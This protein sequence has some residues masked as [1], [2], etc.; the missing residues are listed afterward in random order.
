VKEI[1]Q[2]F[3]ATIIRYPDTIPDVLDIASPDMLITEPLRLA[4]S[5][6]VDMFRADKP[7]DLVTLLKAGGG[8]AVYL[9]RLME[10]TCPLK[11]RLKYYAE[12][13]RKAYQCRQIKAELTRII[14]KVDDEHPDDTIAEVAALVAEH[15]HQSKSSGDILD[16]VARVNAQ[17][18]D[19]RRNGAGLPSGFSFL[20]D[21]THTMHSPGHVWAIG[22]FTSVGKSA[23]SIEMITRMHE[24][25]AGARSCLISTE[26]TESQVVARMIS[27]GSELPTWAILSGKLWDHE[28]E[29]ADQVE[30]WIKSQRLKIFD[31][32]YE[33]T[34]I[35][36]IIRREHLKGGVDMVVVDYMQN[37]TVPGCKSEYEQ[38][39]TTAKAFQRIAKQCKTNIVVLSQ[40]SNDFARNIN[41]GNSLEF[42]GGGTLA[43]VCDLGILL[44][45][46]KNEKTMIMADVRKN[47]H[48]P[49]AK[50]VLQF[51]GKYTRLEEVSDD[52]RNE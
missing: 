47:R 35:E 49:H 6:M 20:D 13:I 32:A 31:D 52:A 41:D 30:E 51:C 48:G 19:T 10:C 24:K 2:S 33:L 3:V 27:R 12:E 16:V 50:Q 45:R 42:K 40:L 8:T 34:N 43:A 4:Y 15:T 9:A 38:H 37:I 17:I 36:G 29:R 25:I 28:K 11:A 39:D 7:V 21:R 46:S 5:T 44:I 23:L 14:T 26:M 1:E 22:A 18:L